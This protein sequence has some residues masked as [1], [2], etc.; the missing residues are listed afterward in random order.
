[1]NA[2]LL[3]MLQVMID[4]YEESCGERPAC[5]KMSPETM[6][7]WLGEEILTHA[8]GLPVI[9]NIYLPPEAVFV[10]DAS[11]FDAEGDVP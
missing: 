10:L 8:L 3:A 9:R 4:A 7:N 11:N 2:E 6:A 1:M 5:I